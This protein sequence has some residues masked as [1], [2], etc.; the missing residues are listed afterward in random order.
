MSN[1]KGFTLIELLVAIGIAVIVIFSAY[2]L[3]F[4]LNKRTKEIYEMIKGREM[5]YN[6]M[7]LIRK[8]IEGVY[9][10]PSI[11]YTGLKLEENDIYGKPASK[12]TF[13]TFFKEGVKVLTYYVEDDNGQLNL[14]KTVQDVTLDSKPIKFVFLKRVEG[15]KVRI[16]DEGFDK[17]Y[18]TEKLKKL[19]KAVKITLVLKEGEKDEEYSEICEIMTAQ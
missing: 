4:T 10:Y 12:L 17:V 19:P 9:Y 16:L 3:Y 13:T 2:T 6:F 8:E 7:T 5:A 11:N 1:K 15:F 18:D 14:V